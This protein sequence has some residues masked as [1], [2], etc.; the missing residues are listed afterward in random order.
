MKQVNLAFNRYVSMW[1]V[2]FSRQAR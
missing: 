1:G 2:T